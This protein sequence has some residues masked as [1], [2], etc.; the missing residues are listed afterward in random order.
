MSARVRPLP[1]VAATLLVAGAYWMCVSTAARLPGTL[2]WR[3][4]VI[5]PIAGLIGGAALARAFA[6]P[7]RRYAVAGALIWIGILSLLL[8]VDGPA[9]WRPARSSAPALEAAAL[10]ILCAGGAWA[11]VAWI[12]RRAPRAPGAPYW[13]VFAILLT[14]GSAQIAEVPVIS[15]LRGEHAA[16]VG[17][18]VLVTAP[19]VAAFITQTLMGHRAV[20]LAASG[21]LAFPLMLLDRGHHFSDQPIGLML[22]AAIFAFG[23]AWLAGWAGAVIAWHVHPGDHPDLPAARLF[24]RDAERDLVEGDDQ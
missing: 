22:F 24:D 9:A 19:A 23:I 6:L 1:L 5:E 11:G 15:F 14:M 21:A 4:Y 20:R 2:D 17:F 3:A 12:A 7:T 8:L 16:G 18:L 10:A 13:C